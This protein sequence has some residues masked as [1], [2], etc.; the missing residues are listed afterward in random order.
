MRFR[1]RCGASGCRPPL[2]FRASCSPAAG[3]ASGPPSSLGSLTGAVS[4]AACRVSQAA[5][6]RASCSQQVLDLRVFGEMFQI[7]G[8]S[9]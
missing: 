5:A 7:N 1:F 9:Q 8:H 4:A 3:G 6:N 2:F